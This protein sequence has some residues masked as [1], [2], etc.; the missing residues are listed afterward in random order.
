MEQTNKTTDI[1]L[2]ETIVEKPVTRTQGNTQQVV[3]T[4]VQH[5]VPLL[6]FTD[7]VVDIPVV[8]LRQI[9]QLQYTDDVVDVP[10]VLVV[11]VPQVQVVAVEIPQLQVVE[12]IGEIPEWL[13]FVRGVVDS[14]IF[15]GISQERLC[16]RTIFACRQEDA[17][18]ESS[19]VR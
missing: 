3:I 12:Q 10:V 7:K 18:E 13:N 16:S 5:V 6:Q 9:S 11:L 15:P 8:T 2:A 4:R 1:S 19:R 14:G 17:C